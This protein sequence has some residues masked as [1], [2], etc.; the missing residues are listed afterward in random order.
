M[1]DLSSIPEVS[2]LIQLSVAPVFLIAGIGGVLGVMANRLSR[3]VDRARVVESLLHTEAAGVGPVHE[4]MV[5]L[6]KR[7][8]IISS[9]IGLCTLTALLVCSVIAIMFLS[10]LF[11]FSTGVPVSVLFIVAMLCF[12]VAL[13]L[14]LREVLLATKTL[15][16]GPVRPDPE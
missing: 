1:S 3:I 15:R 7:A 16:F 6:E 9:A 5:T 8:R 11:A 13:L 2:H 10:A 4:E 14:L 12:I